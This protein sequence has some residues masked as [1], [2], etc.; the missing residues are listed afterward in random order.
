M[1][2]RSK[3]SSVSKTVS[4]LCALV[5]LSACGGGGGT[6]TASNTPPPAA[7]QQLT[8]AQ[9]SAGVFSA[10]VP[11]A[12]VAATKKV[13]QN[14]TRSTF[15]SLSNP[16][17]GCRKSLS[18]VTVFDQTHSI[19]V[20]ATDVSEADLQEAADYAEAAIKKIRA[21]FGVTAPVGFG[22]GKIPVCVQN[23]YINNT[24]I[25]GVA[26]N[27]LQFITVTPSTYMKAFPS[28]DTVVPGYFKYLQEIYK[29]LMTHEVMH[30]YSESISADLKY[31]DP[32]RPNFVLVASS[33][34][35]KWFEEGMARYMEFG[36]NSLLGTRAE[37]VER[38]TR[39]NPMA[40]IGRYGLEPADPD[41]DLSAVVLTYL[42]DP[43]GANNPITRYRTFIDA[44]AVE[45][46]N[47]SLRCASAT[48]P[49]NCPTSLATAEEQ[50]AIVFATTFEAV[51]KEKDGSTMKLRSGTNNLQ[52]SLAARLNTYW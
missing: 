17:Q 13:N 47:L 33:A 15:S 45:W 48:P 49:A 46:S 30:I 41:Y 5:A 51:F 22:L 11:S 32:A 26:S 28:R 29:S 18:N 21:T 20:G 42:F 38:V 9:I 23:E 37:L 12:E 25:P 35:D 2:K 27:L 19:V 8:P 16:N 43:E 24:G 1:N 4:V 34:A 36:K 7:N 6:P 39:N 40:I 50:R 10:Y 14:F 44:F 3:A 52:G 31:R